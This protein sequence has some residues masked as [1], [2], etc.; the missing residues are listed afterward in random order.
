MAAAVDRTRIAVPTSLGDELPGWKWSPIDSQRP[1]LGSVC[2]FHGFAAHSGYAT[3]RYVAELLAGAGFV[4]VSADMH[5]H[6]SAPGERGYVESAQAL[7]DDGVAVAEFAADSLPKPLFFVGSSM[8]GAIALRT[9][10]SLQESGSPVAISGACLL[11][12]M[13]KVNP[14]TVPPSC[15]VAILQ[16]LAAVPWANSVPLISVGGL[17]PEKQYKDEVRRRE[18]TEDPLSYKGKL[19]L[20]TA[21]ALLETTRLLGEELESIDVPLLVMHGDADEVVVPEGSVELN[22]RASSADKTLR[23][24]PGVLHMPLAELPEVRVEIEKEI[25]QWFTQRARQQ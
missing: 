25:V 3:V 5:G 20:A 18:C 24:L 4:C 13:C 16:A 21:S 1:P 12:P 7:V 9:L 2:I 22:E 10:L 11:A 6:G 19:P 23:I 14:K 17:A 15:V 8:G